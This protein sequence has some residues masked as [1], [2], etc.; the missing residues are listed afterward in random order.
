[1]KKIVRTR[2]LQDATIVAEFKGEKVLRDGMNYFY[3]APKQLL[4][5]KAILLPFEV[6]LQISSE[7]SL[8]KDKL[9]E[10]HISKIP[11]K[12]LVDSKAGKIIEGIKGKYD[13][14]Y[15]Y[16]MPNGMCRIISEELAVKM[17]K[18]LKKLERELGE[19]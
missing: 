10:E 2:D 18:D 7:I 12:V 5:E 14:A 13:G 16:V 17:V 6:G 3:V 9:Y 1:M 15:Y 8:K 4:E 11:H 19:K